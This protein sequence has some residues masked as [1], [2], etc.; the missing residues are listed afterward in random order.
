VPGL[1]AGIEWHGYRACPRPNPYGGSSEEVTMTEPEYVDQD[2]SLDQD[3]GIDPA[4]RDPEAPDA[5]AVEQATP[6]NPADEPE[7][8]R[9]GL[10]V[11]EWDALEQARVVDLDEDYR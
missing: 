3:T 2:A 4:E 9:R 7:E 8:V 6:A 1:I 11:D 5:D 10:E